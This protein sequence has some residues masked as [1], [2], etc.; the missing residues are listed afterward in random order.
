[1]ENYAEELVAYH[2]DV[3]EQHFTTYYSECECGQ[4]LEGEAEYD[5][6]DG[7]LYGDDCPACGEGFT[8]MGWFNKCD[9]CSEYHPDEEDCGKDNQE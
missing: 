8:V 2:S 4:V 5:R 3:E 7:T 6:V 1:M 9:W